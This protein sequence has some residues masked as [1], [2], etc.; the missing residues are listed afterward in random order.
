VGTSG[1]LPQVD[2]EKAREAGAAIGERVAEGANEAQKAL[3][4]T[5]LTGKIKSKMALD[6]T[7]KASGIH[8][9]TRDGAVTLT[10]TVGSDAERRRA[11]QLAKET[12]G[13]TSVT[14]RLTIR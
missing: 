2:A 12:K 3:A 9:E 7:I 10:G 14:D 6:D 13:V 1:H 5:T 11:V 8:V 4:N